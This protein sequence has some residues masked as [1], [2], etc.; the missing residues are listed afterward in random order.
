MPTAFWKEDWA[1]AR[2]NFTAWWKQEGS[3]FCVMAPAD[4]PHEELEPPLF[5]PPFCQPCFAKGFFD[6]PT[7]PPPNDARPLEEYWWDASFRF[8]VSEY[9]LSRTF[10]GGECFPYID[11]QIGPGNLAAFLG[12]SVTYEPTTVWFGELMESLEEHSELCLNTNN[13]HW[14]RQK[15]LVENAVRSAHGRFLVSMPDLIENVD[16][17]AS[18]RGAQNVMMDMALTPDLVTQRVAEIN[19]VYTEVFDAL[20]ELIKDEYNGNSFS[21][22][23]IWGPGRT[24]KVQCDLSAMFSPAMFDSCVAPGLEE[25][26]ADYEY[27]LY[28]LDGQQALPHLDT[29]LGMPDIHAIEWTPEPGAP[30]GGSL[31]WVDLYKKIL[32]GGKSVQIISVH[33]EEA[34]LLLKELGSEGVY[35]TITCETE[36]QARELLHQL[37]KYR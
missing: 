19:E 36:T 26:C 22:F 1:D 31:E 12:S 4:T 32:N 33:P 28:H 34:E 6:L 13:V 8:S 24:T 30:H 20:F 27:V 18:L 29:L 14:K 3:A 7:T 23:H 16:I 25:Q 17:L 2:A 11:T 10:F 37:E 35:L 15:M 21:C 5:V 9:L